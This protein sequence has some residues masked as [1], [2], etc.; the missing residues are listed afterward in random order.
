[1]STS[2]GSPCYAAPELVVSDGLYVGSAV[3][4]WSC[5]V[6]LYAMLCGYLPFDDDPENPDGDNINLLYKYIL[7]TP[8]AFPDY[9]SEDARDLLRK[10]LV[11]DPKKRCSMKTIMEHPWLSEHRD[12]FKKSVE[13]LEKEVVDPIALPLA[14]MPPQPELPLSPV[15][16][17]NIPGTTDRTE[18]PI[19]VQSPPSEPDDAKPTAED[20][21]TVPNQE[22]EASGEAM[23]IDQKEEQQTVQSD[24]T[25]RASDAK[26]VEA[27]TEEEK[28]KVPDIHVSERE[29]SMTRDI[30][31]LEL[32]AAAHADNESTSGKDATMSDQRS[33]TSES[34]MSEDAPRPSPQPSK[35][36]SKRVHQRGAEKLL[37]F[38]SG[39][40]TADS[41]AERQTSP[42]R[43]TR[44]TTRPFS[45]SVEQQRP[46]SGHHSILH[47]KFLSSM[48]RHQQQQQQDIKAVPGAR[49]EGP[50]ISMSTPQGVG[51]TRQQLALKPLPRAPQEPSRSSMPATTTS[52]Q[53]TV[54]TSH[55]VRGTR[56]KALSLFV[57]PMATENDTK[58]TGSVSS[59]RPAPRYQQPHSSRSRLLAN[60][61]NRQSSIPPS[62]SERNTRLPPSPTSPEV[63]PK[64]YKHRSAGKK[65]MD[66]FKKKPLSKC[67]FFAFVV[68][69]LNRSKNRYQRQ[70]LRAVG[71]PAIQ[72][73]FSYASHA[74][75]Q[76]ARSLCSGFQ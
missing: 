52:P 72:P 70:T 60:K 47:A 30:S 4:I 27:L 45:T 5:G 64:D 63:L 16:N 59:K 1:M 53:P 14:A 41:I 44:K 11:P 36:V 31:S 57:N 6:I 49:N 28:D 38:L 71:A 62:V 48:Q 74:H 69:C 55:P 39:T 9:V 25:P 20:D 65:L 40:R 7:N 12:L 37:S 75:W 29:E 67:F 35:T 73:N 22:E 23:E 50:T 56:R 2:C 10:M 43:T 15:G 33:A 18:P 42:G 68:S 26:E 24:E 17:P 58:L 13:E 21:Q 54:G 19:A 32:P 66:W 34:R 3:D 8:L 61:E 76:A 46:P 51:I